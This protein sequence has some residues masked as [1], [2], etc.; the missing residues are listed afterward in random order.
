[1]NIHTPPPARGRKRAASSPPPLDEEPDV[2]GV[3]SNDI[4][5]RTATRARIASDLDNLGLIPKEEAW[6]LNL[7][8]V[9]GSDRRLKNPNG[10]V[11]LCTIGTM[12]VQID[13][14]T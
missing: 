2:V 14:T 10:P 9:L 3:E 7:D 4:A 1:M 11:L 6:Q 5:E 12:N 13:L 8:E